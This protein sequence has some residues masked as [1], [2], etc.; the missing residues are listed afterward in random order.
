ML[1]FV[2]HKRW[3]FIP[4]DDQKLSKDLEQKTDVTIQPVRKITQAIPW[5]MLGQD[6][7]QRDQ[8]VS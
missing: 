2:I 6:Q 7:W 5:K 4:Q 1:L 8:L 3:D